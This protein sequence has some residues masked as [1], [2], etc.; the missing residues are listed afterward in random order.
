MAHKILAFGDRQRTKQHVGE[1]SLTQQHMQAE[2]DVNNIMAKYQKHQIIT[3]VSKY[4]GEYGDF[5]GVPDY[6]EGLER[7]MAAEEMFQSLPAKIR[8]RFANDPA[9]F[10]E[11]ATNAEN[12]PEL[13]KMGLAPPEA[14]P[15]KPQLVQVVEP[16]E[17]GKP[18]SK[19]PKPEQGDQ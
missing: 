18:P 13:R 9:N 17:G 15:P 16:P 7:I 2:T 4:A 19:K 6:R 3:H 12:L 8:D 5:S 10:I 1:E 14:E 11:F